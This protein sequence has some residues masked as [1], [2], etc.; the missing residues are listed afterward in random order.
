MSDEQYESWWRE[1][2]ER[3]LRVAAETYALY[4]IDEDQ[5]LRRTARMLELKRGC[6]R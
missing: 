1:V 4:R 6:R 3:A 2:Q 5:Q